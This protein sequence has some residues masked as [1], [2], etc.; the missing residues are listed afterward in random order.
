MED[1]LNGRWITTSE[2]EE[3]QLRFWA[4]FDDIEV[5]YRGGE[6]LHGV[7]GSRIGAEFLR[8]NQN[9]LA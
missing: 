9:L 6:P 4:L 5:H 2:D 8:S 3:L 7:I 1:R